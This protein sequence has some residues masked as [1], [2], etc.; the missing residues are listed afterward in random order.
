MAL[1]RALRADV[2]R[3]EEVVQAL[4]AEVAQ[5]REKRAFE[6]GARKKAEEEVDARKVAVFACRLA[7]GCRTGS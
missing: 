6:E 7:C 5:E 3:Q 4:R 1:A 2:K